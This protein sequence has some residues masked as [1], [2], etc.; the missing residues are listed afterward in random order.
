MRETFKTDADYVV[1]FGRLIEASRDLAEM[2]FST[3]PVLEDVKIT[4]CD[5]GRMPK[6]F[7]FETSSPIHQQNLKVGQPVVVKV[8]TNHMTNDYIASV[9]FAK[10][11]RNATTIR[12]QFQQ[13]KASPS[14]LDGG[15]QISV[16]V[17]FQDAT[18]RRQLEALEIFH[19]L[20]QPLKATILG[21]PLAVPQERTPPRVT[22]LNLDA[23]DDEEDGV[24][25][26]CWPT[27]SAG[28]Q[29]LASS[30]PSVLTAIETDS[31]TGTGCAAQ[32]SSADDD[33]AEG[34]N[35]SQQRAVAMVLDSQILLIQVLFELP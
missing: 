8:L 2:D 31:H 35:V 23:S 22:A 7:C 12:V 15:C 34:L 30:P 5:A 32:I 17:A 19:W 1:H 27:M 11:H 26:C 21:V 24:F 16:E 25:S 29:Q 28:R 20:P 18:Y 3:I 9:K 14:R 13:D 33:A 6:W 10:T 4:G